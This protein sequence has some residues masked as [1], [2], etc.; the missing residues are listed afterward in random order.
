[1]SMRVLGQNTKAAT[2]LENFTPG[3]CLHDADMHYRRYGSPFTQLSH[4]PS[5]GLD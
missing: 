1:M 4:R 2:V 3:A 5:S